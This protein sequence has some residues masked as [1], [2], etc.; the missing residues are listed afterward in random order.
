MISLQN[1]T[2]VDAP[3]FGFASVDKGDVTVVIPTLNEEKA[4]ELV[5]RG[6]RSEDYHN[7]LVVDGNSRDE[8]LRIAKRMRVR[9]ATQ[10]GKG[11]TGAVATAISLIKTPYF[12]LIDG[13]YTYDPGD[14]EKL[15]EKASEYSHVIGA[16]A[17]RANIPLFNRFGNSMINLMFNM[18]F[19]SDLRDVCSGL[20][21]IRT[22]WAK[23]LVLE[24]EGFGVEVELAARSALDK[25]VTEV[26]ISYRSRIGMQKLNPIKDGLRIGYTINLL[27]RKHNVPLYKAVLI[28]G[29]LALLGFSY[30][31][32][33]NM[34]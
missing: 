26:P 8:T 24:S 15:I 21:L 27:A 11:K 34:F 23:G 6:L 17:E 18:Y 12:V 1:I 5:I 3:G 10:V 25:V 32:I 20:Y 28:T 31:L 19:G 2:A 30:L 22:S 4:I 33:D 14:I 29:C 16:R 7:I 9:T 13:D